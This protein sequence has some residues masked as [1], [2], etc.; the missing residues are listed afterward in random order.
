MMWLQ[1]FAAAVSAAQEVIDMAR[2]SEH[3]EL[4]EK[5]IKLEKER[6]PR[7]DPRWKSINVAIEK[8]EPR[9]NKNASTS[10]A[11]KSDQTE[12]IDYVRSQILH[13]FSSYEI[14]D[15]SGI[16]QSW[17]N[18]LMHDYHIHRPPIA[19]FRLYN[20]ETEEVRY[21]G[22][23]AEVIKFFKRSAFRLGLDKHNTVFTGDWAINRGRWYQDKYGKWNI[24]EG[25]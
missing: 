20:F 16:S 12:R 15:I 8:K 24:T 14:A 7:G 2:L 23:L 10:K 4:M 17:I 22:T 1:A 9:N 13:G 21:L 25:K 6:A 11:K 18:K 5:I 19:H 3:P